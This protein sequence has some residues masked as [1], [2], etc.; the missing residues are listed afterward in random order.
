MCEERNR[1]YK[2]QGLLVIAGMQGSIVIAVINSM[3]LTCSS[4]QSPRVPQNP[5]TYPT[6]PYPTL[7]YTTN[8]SPTANPY[9]HD[10][11][12]SQ[13]TTEPAHQGLVGQHQDKGP[14]HITQAIP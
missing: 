9:L 14:L 7:P 4:T 3:P 1:F 13:G 11:A 2:C 6:L 10:H 12:V 5:P 8:P